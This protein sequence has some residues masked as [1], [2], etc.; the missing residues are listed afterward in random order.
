MGDSNQCNSV[1]TISVE[2]QAEAAGALLR[3][4]FRRKR[5]AMPVAAGT[6]GPFYNTVRFAIKKGKD[7]IPR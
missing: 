4:P 6:G 3:L 2:K 7:V 5:P 1:N